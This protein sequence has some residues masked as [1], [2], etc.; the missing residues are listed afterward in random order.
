MK[1]FRNIAFGMLT[2]AM[3]ASSTYA[4]AD[5]KFVTVDTVR[6]HGGNSIFSTLTATEMSSIQDG[7]RRANWRRGV[8]ES[9]TGRKG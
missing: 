9:P 8:G 2:T 6:S 1:T 5:G 7:E 3:V 4:V